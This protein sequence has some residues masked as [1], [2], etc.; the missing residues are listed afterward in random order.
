MNNLLENL[1]SEQ[2]KAVMHKDGPLLII[3]GAGTGKTTIIAQRIAY[4]IE[5][6]WPSRTKY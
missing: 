4:L 3:A 5:Q 2:L 1:N 6:V